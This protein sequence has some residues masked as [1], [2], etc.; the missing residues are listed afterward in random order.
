MDGRAALVVPAGA[1]PTACK[2]VLVLLDTAARLNVPAFTSTNVEVVPDAGVVTHA[3]VRKGF[4]EPLTLILKY[5]PAKI[6]AGAD[7]AQLRMGRAVQGV[8][9]MWDPTFGTCSY[10]TAD[11]VVVLAEA[12]LRVDDHEMRVAVSDSL[13]QTYLIVV[14]KSSITGTSRAAST[15]FADLPP[16]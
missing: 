9:T 7:V 4:R 3:P 16:R 6:P 1:I 15:A 11:T 13:Y 5:D 8:C 12:E 14:P 10:V 2:E